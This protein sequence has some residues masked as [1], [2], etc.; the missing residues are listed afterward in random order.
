MF[1]SYQWDIQETVKELKDRLEKAGFQ[2]W[3]D[4]NQMGGGDALNAEIDA[5]IRASKVGYLISSI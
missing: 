3:M 5:G 4:I 1:I 2:C